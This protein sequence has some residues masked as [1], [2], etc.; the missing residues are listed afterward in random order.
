MY[1]LNN[2]IVTIEYLNILSATY[3]NNSVAITECQKYIP[4]AIVAAGH[5]T[6]M[7]IMK[8]WIYLNYVA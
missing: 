7:K 2:S 1:Y 6:Y 3:L 8:G 4:S 5:D